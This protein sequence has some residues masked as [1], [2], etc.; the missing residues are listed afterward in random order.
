[1]SKLNRESFS[2]VKESEWQEYEYLYDLINVEK[3][4][5]N[6]QWYHPKEELYPLLKRIAE[7]YIH[8]QIL[9]NSLIILLEKDGE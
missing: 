2:D 6:L 4:N 1:M 9:R 3:R 7:S 5:P 8:E